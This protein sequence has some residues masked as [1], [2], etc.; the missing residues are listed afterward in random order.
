[1]KYDALQILVFVVTFVLPVLVGASGGDFMKAVALAASSVFLAHLLFGVLFGGW[2][3]SGSLESRML[4]AAATV[5][6]SVP[7]GAAGFAVRRLWLY[8]NRGPRLGTRH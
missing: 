7:L 8:V 6:L 3:G 1:M 5:P 4:A 2:D